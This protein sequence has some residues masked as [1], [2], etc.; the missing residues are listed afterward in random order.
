MNKSHEIQI[1]Q[2]IAM[3]RYKIETNLCR[4][5]LKGKVV[6]ILGNISIPQ[7]LLC[8]ITVKNKIFEIFTF[9]LYS[10]ISSLIVKLVCSSLRMLQ[11]V[12]V[13]I[14]SIIKN[15]GS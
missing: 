9:R 7:T 14:I 4:Q 15:L 13:V 5:N 8:G 11:S 1:T 2:V 3:T 6:H 10:K 12:A